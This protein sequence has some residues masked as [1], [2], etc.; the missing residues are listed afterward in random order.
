MPQ[1]VLNYFIGMIPV[2]QAMESLRRVTEMQVASGV[3]DNASDIWSKWQELVD[4]YAPQDDAPKYPYPSEEHFMVHMMALGGKVESGNG[5][6]A[7][8]NGSG[9]KTDG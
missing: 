2:V 8:V 7:P 9:G 3:L 1:D 5:K 6:I 4:T